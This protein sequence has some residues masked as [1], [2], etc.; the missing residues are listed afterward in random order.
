[1]YSIRTEQQ[2]NHYAMLCYLFGVVLYVCMLCMYACMYES[3]FVQVAVRASRQAEGQAEQKQAELDTL[4]LGYRTSERR[5]DDI[6]RQIRDHEMQLDSRRDT[7]KG[8][9]ID[10]ERISKDQATIRKEEDA[11]R[12]QSQVMHKTLPSIIVLLLLLLFDIVY[13]CLSDVHLMYVLHVMSCVDADS[14]IV[15]RA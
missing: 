15:H 9:D 13:T 2:W 3:M 7:M 10:R 1:M 6:K 5:L 12:H 14:S 4:L 8:L 11:L